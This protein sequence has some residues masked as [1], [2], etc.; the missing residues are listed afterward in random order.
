M[1]G[2]SQSPALFSKEQ[3][4]APPP[5]SRRCSPGQLWI[6]VHLSDLALRAVADADLETPTAVV[7]PRDGQLRI[8]AA[9]ERAR[10]AGI[11]A[12][13]TASAG[14]ALVDSLE[15]VERSVTAERASLESLAVWADELTPIVS[16]EPPETLLL[17]VRGS[18]RFF[19]GLENIKR[20]L[21]VELDRRRLRFNLGTA[22]TPLAAHWLARH[23][24]CGNTDVVSHREL[25]SRLAA[26]PVSVAGWPD[27]IQRLLRQ[28][29][30]C[31][32]G[33]CL[34]LPRGGFA[35]RIGKRYL[36]ELDRAMARQPDPRRRFEGP[37]RLSW[38]IDFGSET[39]D[40]GI[41]VRSLETGIG[42]MAA[43]LRARQAQ[44]RAVEIA[45]CH[46]HGVRTTSLVR[47]VE[48]VHERERMLAPLISRLERLELDRPV[49]ALGLRTDPLRPMQADTARLFGDF[50]D[51]NAAHVSELALIECLR[52]RF[53]TDGVHGLALQA[54][55]RPEL[56]WGKLTEELSQSIAS[57]T[58]PSPW[59]NERPLWILS[60]PESLSAGF[61]AVSGRVELES[62]PE[63]IESGWWDGRDVR[64]DYYA[65]VTASGERLWVYQDRRTRRW[66][67]HGI[68]G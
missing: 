2:S 49:V 68:F 25:T 42:C 30:V 54:E 5:A 16:L 34:R 50:A 43:D 1:A 58:E 11:D 46:L 62:E 52:G 61:P 18:L 53:G 37:R 26:L 38:T 4:P 32:I 19:S 66:Y 9:N 59:A 21:G 29:G 40:R 3:A 13:L 22:P 39:T 6:A 63:R 27:P 47:F 64:R 41:F 44:V 67:L 23:G 55:H 7:E 51:G 33:A 65:A 8:V 35:R 60:A 31:T 17:E 57:T 10:R 14:F 24:R 28:M 12:G 15:L 20:M 48:P 56:A 45:F 36:D